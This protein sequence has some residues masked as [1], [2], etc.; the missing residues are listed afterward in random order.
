MHMHTRTHYT[1]T[2][3]TAVRA[4]VD[5]L[6]HQ[7]KSVAQFTH[8]H[9]REHTHAHAHTHTL[10]THDTHRSARRC[11]FSAPSIKIGCTIHTHT[12]D[13]HE[14]T[15][16]CMHTR[17]HYTHTTHTAVRAGVDF[18]L[19]QLKSVAQF[20]HTHTRTHTCTC[21]HAHTTHTRHT[22][23]CAQVWIFCSIN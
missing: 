21:T 19:H 14:H 15:H 5:F 11:G 1:H 9:T 2:T 17:T 22:P 12:R 13:T 10:H 23:Q 16:T 20:T 6:L 8:T 4:G 3:H 7:L 18:L